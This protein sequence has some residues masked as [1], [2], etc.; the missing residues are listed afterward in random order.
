MQSDSIRERNRRTEGDA[1]VQDEVSSEHLAQLSVHEKLWYR[2]AQ[3]PL[4]RSSA[5]SEP[6]SRRKHTPVMGRTAIVTSLLLRSC[7]GEGARLSREYRGAG[8]FRCGQAGPS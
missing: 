6:L 7:S 1:E 3:A 4:A 8:E 5:K 2:E